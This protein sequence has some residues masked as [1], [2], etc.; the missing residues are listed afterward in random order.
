MT[1]A[2]KPRKKKVGEISIREDLNVKG[3]VLTDEYQKF[4]DIFIPADMLLSMA[5]QLCS[6]GLYFKDQSRPNPCTK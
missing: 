4:A 5:Y 2:K 1:K 6:W 3:I